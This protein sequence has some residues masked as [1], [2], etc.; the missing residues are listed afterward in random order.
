PLH[1]PTADQYV[2]AL[3]RA[4]NE[5]VTASALGQ[6]LRELDVPP[7][8]SRGVIVQRARELLRRRKIDPARASQAEWLDALKEAASQ[9]SRGEALKETRASRRDQVIAEAVEE[10]KML[11]VHAEAYAALWDDD[12][13]RTES[14]LAQIPPAMVWGAYTH[15]V[16]GRAVERPDERGL[17]LHL[18]A[19]RRLLLAGKVN[20][21]GA[22]EYDADDYL[23]MLGKIER[24][25]EFARESE[26]NE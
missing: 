23:E 3:E 24:E 16:H 5:T 7:E 18:E 9:L 19:E 11:A 2:T 10:G 12:P 15:T 4:G 6:A 20:R 1:R 14:I 21:D 22:L 26:E 13:E 8:L 25:Q 17:L